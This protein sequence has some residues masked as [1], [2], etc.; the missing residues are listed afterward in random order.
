MKRLNNETIINYLEF[1]KSV[2]KNGEEIYV[3]S[4]LGVFDEPT[5]YLKRNKF[6]HQ[7]II[8]K[9]INKNYLLRMGNASVFISALEE[10]NDFLQVVNPRNFQPPY[11]NYLKAT[12]LVRMG[13]QESN[14]LFGEQYIQNY[15]SF[16][17][18]VKRVSNTSSNSDYRWQVNVSF[19]QLTDIRYYSY[20]VPCYFTCIIYS[21]SQFVC[22][23]EFLKKY[24][25]LKLE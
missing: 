21:I 16:D 17:V 2:T 24:F 11:L 12:D 8:Q 22:V 1:Q 4:E 7:K 20:I 3:K 18:L 14:V 10:Y 25:K 23:L 19:Q 9:G 6:S 5:I 13:F 15:N